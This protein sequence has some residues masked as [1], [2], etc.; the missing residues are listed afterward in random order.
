MDEPNRKFFKT[1]TIVWGSAPF[2]AFVAAPPIAAFS[3]VP[4]EPVLYWYHAM[5]TGAALMFPLCFGTLILS[6]ITLKLGYLSVA[7]SLMF[8]PA[9][10]IAAYWLTVVALRA[11]WGDAISCPYFALEPLSR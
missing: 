2:I 8:M 9:V 5:A 6:K 3:C 11:Y 10:A 4:H 7:R 1:A